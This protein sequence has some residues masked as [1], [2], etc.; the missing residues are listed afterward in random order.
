MSGDSVA[1]AT[2]TIVMVVCREIAVGRRNWN[3]RSE[4]TEDG[5]DREKLSELHLW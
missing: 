3:C 4:R 1:Q 2:K 5:D